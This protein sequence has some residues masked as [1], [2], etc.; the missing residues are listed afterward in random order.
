MHRHPFPLAR[1]CQRD[2]RWKG[3]IANAV[4]A[5]VSVQ[6]DVQRLVDETVEEFGSPDVTPRLK[7][8]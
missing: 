4:Q 7:R 3:G 8:G 2:I 6:P 1:S 5:D